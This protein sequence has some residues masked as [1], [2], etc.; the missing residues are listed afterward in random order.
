MFF[1]NIR[2][3]GMGKITRQLFLVSFLFVVI[4]SAAAESYERTW[5]L[6]SQGFYEEAYKEIERSTGPLS[7][8]SL[9]LL[10]EMHFLGRGTK[11]D[12]SLGRK[13]IQ[14]ASSKSLS[15]KHANLPSGLKP[16]CSSSNTLCSDVLKSKAFV[17]P[18]AQFLDKKKEMFGLYGCERSSLFP[19]ALFYY[20]YD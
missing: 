10:G 12:L 1:Q 5:A 13:F 7:Q 4:K 6:Y 2:F 15:S 8:S 17:A 16:I 9:W 3:S 19:L 14:Q 18:F 11:A 20:Q